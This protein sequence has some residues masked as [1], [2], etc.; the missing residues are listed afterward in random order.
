MSLQLI[1]YFR[2][3]LVNFIDEIIEQFPDKPDF[4]LVKLIVK[5]KVSM[6]DVM[7]RYI[8]TVI[9]EKDVIVNRNLDF[10]KKDFVKGYEDWPNLN[11][12]FLEVKSLYF[13]DRLDDDERDT[14][15]KWMDLFLRICEKY[16]IKYGPIEG[17]DIKEKDRNKPFV[18]EILQK[19][20]EY[21][22][23]NS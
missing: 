6:T 23:Q 14:I 9:P 4:V 19:R 12:I 1:A 16:Y 5:D 7:G 21:I 3:K 11:R 18:K 2:D 13:S 22:R 17:W 20:E 10:F 8:Q 15:W